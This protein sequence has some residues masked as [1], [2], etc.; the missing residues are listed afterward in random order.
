MSLSRLLAGRKRES[1]V[2]E[3]F[4]YDDKTNK[5]ACLVK[6]GSDVNTKPC[7]LQLM[8]KNPTNLKVNNI[9]FNYLISLPK[10]VLKQ[11]DGSN[12]FRASPLIVLK[13]QD[14]VD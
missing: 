8:G 6:V 9:T 3:Y 10:G 4:K 14:R 7:G 5:S 11:F 2:W 12:F 13:F 1:E